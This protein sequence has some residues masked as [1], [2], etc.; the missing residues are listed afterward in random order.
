MAP[1]LETPRLE[2]RRL[3]ED[4]APFMV[5]LLNDPSFIRNIGDRGVRTLDEAREYLAQGPMASYAR[6]GFG[7]YLVELREPRTPIGICGILK[8][9][10][11]PEPDIG[12]AFLPAYWS[13]GYAREAAAAV[14]A[15]ARDILA[16]PRLLAIVSPSN[17]SSIRLLEKIGFTFSSLSRLTPEADEVKLYSCPLR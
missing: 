8:R 4:D 3:C 11:L 12:F 10:Q 6:F 15:Y 7:L 5:E 1:L 17:H 14:K 9:D 13:Q 2:L 16:L